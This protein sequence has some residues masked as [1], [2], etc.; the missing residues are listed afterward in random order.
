MGFLIIFGRNLEKNHI[1]F[2]GQ[3]CPLFI[4]DLSLTLQVLFVS[5]KNI[6]EFFVAV[7]LSL[8]EPSILYRLK[9]FNIGNIIDQKCTNNSSVVASSNGSVVL[10]SG[11]VPDLEP[12]FLLLKID[13]FVPELDADRW[14]GVLIEPPMK[15]LIEKT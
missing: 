1:H 13:L 4:G 9:G 12:D 14:I 3:I 11:G 2:S 15:V 6:I 5:H 8:V 7:N 10:L